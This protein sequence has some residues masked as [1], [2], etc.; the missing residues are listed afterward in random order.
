MTHWHDQFLSLIVSHKPHVFVYDK[1]QLLMHE[2]LQE[3]AAN[4][5]FV[6]VRCDTSL[7]LRIAFE[8]DIRH[9][10][11]RYLIHSANDFKPLPDIR[12]LMGCAKVSIGDIF[13]C[14]D[15]KTISGLDGRIL[16][17]LF[18]LSKKIFDSLGPDQTIKFVLE[19]IYFVDVD[20]L[21]SKERLLSSLTTIFSEPYALNQPVL[22]YLSKRFTKHFPGIPSETVSQKS[23][24]PFLQ[25][26]WEAYILNGSQ[27]INFEESSL[28]K[29]V[30][31][32]F[33]TGRLAP[34]KVNRRT[35]QDRKSKIGIF[36]DERQSRQE[37]ADLLMDYISTYLERIENDPRQW[38]SLIQLIAKNKLIVL[39]LNDDEL[40]AVTER[41]EKRINRRF[42]IFLDNSYQSLQS[43]S[44]V[45]QPYHVFRVLDYLKNHSADKKALVVIDGLNYWQWRIVETMLTQKGLP[46]IS[47]ATFA[48]I[49]S[50]TAWSRQALFKGARPDLSTD[51]SNEDKL[52]MAYWRNAGYSGYQTAFRRVETAS[53]GFGAALPEA[54]PACPLIIGMVCNDIDD[55][56]HGNV[57]GLSQF[58]IDTHHWLEKCDLTSMILN[59]RQSGFTVFVTS[60]HGSI[61]AR[62]IK[63][64]KLSEKFGSLSRSKRHLH[65]ANES[66]LKS[67]QQNNPDLDAGVL[68]LSLYLKDNSAFVSPNDVVITHGGSHFWEVLVPFAE[69]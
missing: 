12:E 18:T 26:K 36:H 38:F 57:L 63:N 37:D 35:W 41:L 69:I 55:M 17:V 66:F 34:V 61:E 64:L 54:G 5:G 31:N 8:L 48:W 56:M 6:I 59:L 15:R 39:D 4:A 25:S 16:D 53:G 52:F 47:S 3:A 22:D 13:P 24:Y 65:F 68:D 42:Q 9:S 1:D 7:D 44:A 27:E 45:K 21:G 60:D 30:I 28:N 67:F 49:P 43:R 62:G 50:I 11:A 2:S 33:V 14:L 10:D 51:N 58:Y 20:G 29:T 40:T 23:F 19:N 32:A 46:C